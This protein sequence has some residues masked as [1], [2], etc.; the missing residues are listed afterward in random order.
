MYAAYFLFERPGE[1]A[2]ARLE[3]TGRDRVT[4]LLVEVA[5]RSL[6]R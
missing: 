1:L 6:T 5:K 3:F 2:S 4:L